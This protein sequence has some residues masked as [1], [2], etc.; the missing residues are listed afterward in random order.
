M[1]FLDCEKRA[2]GPAAQ[3]FL[4]M[5][6]FVILLQRCAT[7]EKVQIARKT[8]QEQIVAQTVSDAISFFSRNYI[9]PAL[10]TTI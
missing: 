6:L 5:M 9:T 8:R 1:L 7:A 10:T 2:G 4:A 3:G